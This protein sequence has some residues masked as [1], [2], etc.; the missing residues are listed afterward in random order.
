MFAN[1]LYILA[2]N[3]FDTYCQSTDYYEFL[4]YEYASMCI[5]IIGRAKTVLYE[6]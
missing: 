6:M 2:V 4:W 3:V 1:L 5:S